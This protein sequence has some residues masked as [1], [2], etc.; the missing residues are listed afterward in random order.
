[1]DN[2]VFNEPKFTGQERQPN[3]SWGARLVKW[4]A[5]KFNGKITETK[6][7]NYLIIGSIIIIGIAVLI[8]MFVG[9]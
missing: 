3:P 6:A 5:L 9:T 1:M 7:N 8:A 2:I 4:L